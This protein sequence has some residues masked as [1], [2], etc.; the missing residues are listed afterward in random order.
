MSNTYGSSQ[1]GLNTYGTTTELSKEELEKYFIDLYKYVPDFIQEIPETNAI[2]KVEGLELGT[3]AYQIEDVKNQF[4]IDTATWG[5]SLWEEKYGIETN[6]SLTYESR[7]EIVK[8][9]K[10]VRGTATIKRIQNAA[11]SFSGGAVQIIPHNEE[12]Y[13]IV[14]FVGVKGIP[15]NMDGFI[16]ALEIIKPAHLGYVFEYTYLTWDQFDAYNFKADE[17]DL[18]KWDELEVM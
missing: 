16:E 14:K 11:E 3:L 9:R 7:R 4:R 18:T 6:L 13:F 10:R 8:S 17:L 5:L 1:Y 12:Y 15:K 2:Y